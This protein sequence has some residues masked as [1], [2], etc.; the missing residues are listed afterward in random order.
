MNEVYALYEEKKLNFALSGS[1]AR[2]LRRGG[3]NLLAGR[4]L[5]IFMFPLAGNELNKIK[6]I[7]EAVDWGSLP[8][9]ILEP[10]YKKKTLSTYVET[11]LREEL[12]QEGFL[13]KLDPFVRFLSVAGIMNAQVLNMDSIS[14]EASI[15]RTSAQNYFEILVDTLIGFYLRRI[16]PD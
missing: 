15:A 2:K 14:R 1:S 16:G 3:G 7:D 13:R 12:V 9:V 5:Q 8:G 6:S 4:A 11:Y 10:E